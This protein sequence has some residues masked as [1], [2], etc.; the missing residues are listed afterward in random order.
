VGQNRA[1]STEITGY[2][3]SALVFLHTRTGD[4]RYLEG[5]SQAGRFLTRLAWDSK[6]ELFPFEYYEKGEA[7]QPARSYFFDCGII[8]RGLLRLWRVT[9][10][11]ELLH[12]AEA[13]GHAMQKDFAAGGSEYHPILMLPGRDPQ[14][15]ADQWSR[16]PGCYQLKAALGWL[17]IDG[18]ISSGA[19]LTSYEDL[20]STSLATHASFLPGA[21]GDRV[22]D[23]LHAYCYFLEGLCPRLNRPEVAAAMKVGIAT[24][25]EQIG[26]LGPH[27]VRSD[28][29][30][31]L[32]RVQ[33][34]A[35]RAGVV[36][37]D[38]AEAERRAKTISVFQ[39]EGADPR[40][41]GGYLFAR[42]NGEL[43]PHVNPVSTA[44]GLQA[45]T[46]WGDYL[47]GDLPF[48]PET[49]I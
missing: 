31:Q 33:L 30:A 49:L 3:I 8:V 2:A 28:V 48:S 4:E 1:I 6:L 29:H 43:Q 16:L 32:L 35:D 19:F 13:C 21:V 20:L 11:A 40:V 22:M 14:P 37:L 27:F 36:P 46:M 23:R 34:L 38:H 26:A 44:F 24:V 7:S 42:R 39:S 45:L 41:H 9:K 12:I 10:D 47:A 18:A 17:E 15:R 5:A 25:I